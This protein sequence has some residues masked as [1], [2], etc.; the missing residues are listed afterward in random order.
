MNKRNTRLLEV[1]SLVEKNKNNNDN[2]LF[3]QADHLTDH[4]KPAKPILTRLGDNLDQLKTS[5][6]LEPESFQ[7][8]S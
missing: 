8:G 7:Q 1:P 6:Q 4:V 5:K 3:S 2:L